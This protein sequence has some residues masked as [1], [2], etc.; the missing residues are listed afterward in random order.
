MWLPK[1]LRKLTKPFSHSAV[2]Q[3]PVN[4]M[5]NTS[6]RPVGLAVLPW[7]VVNETDVWHGAANT[8]DK[9]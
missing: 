9:R 6:G 8:S 4:A 7:G 1:R 3:S 2:A 5:S